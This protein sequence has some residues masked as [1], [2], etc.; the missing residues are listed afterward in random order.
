MSFV[1]SKIFW[2]L[3]QPGNLVLLALG[4]AA[5]LAGKR[6]IFARR[7]L[8]TTVVLLLVTTFLPV[9]QW[10]RLPIERRFP[11]LIA[12]PEKIDGIV[13]LGGAVDVSSSIG[14]TYLEL[15]KSAERIIASADVARRRP[16]AKLVYS[17]F[18]GRLI[19]VTD[20]TPGIVD[21]YVR[22]GVERDRVILE[23][24]S[25]NTYENAILSKELADPAPGETWLLVTSAYHMPRAVGVFEQLGWPVVPM[26]VDFRQPSQLE[27]RGYLSNIAQPSLSSRVGEVD[28]AVKAWLGLA[29]YWLL[30]RTNTLLPGP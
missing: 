5:V 13:V 28:Q 15:N 30:G 2:S 10:L 12:L 14:R 27:L 3:T 20:E 21:F 17:G 23:S 6:P 4:I 8:R 16:D 29:A 26:P 7:L 18:R 24:Q 19:D 25:R 22:H 1:L 9:G 11:E